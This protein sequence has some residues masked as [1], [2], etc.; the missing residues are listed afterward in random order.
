VRLVDLNARIPKMEIVALE[1]VG[2]REGKT[3]GAVLTKE[4]LDFVSTHSE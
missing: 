2:A 1:R 4:L 3:I